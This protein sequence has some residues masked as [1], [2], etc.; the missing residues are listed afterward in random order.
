MNLM[1]YEDFC[2]RME[3]A[4]MMERAESGRK[5]IEDARAES[6]QGVYIHRDL[7]CAVGRKPVE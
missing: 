2:A 3:E 6:R 1:A 4:G 7:I 5:T